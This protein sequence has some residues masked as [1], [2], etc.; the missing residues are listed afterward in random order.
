MGTRNREVNETN[1]FPK[2]GGKTNRLAHTIG[3]G[4]CD[5]SDVTGTNLRRRQS[6]QPSLDGCILQLVVV[7]GFSNS[8]SKQSQHHETKIIFPTKDAGTTGHPKINA[9]TDFILFTN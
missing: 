2:F 3:Q 6:T 9:D 8:A 5:R 7:S 1:M 4:C